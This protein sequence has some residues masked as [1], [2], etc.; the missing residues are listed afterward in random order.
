MIMSII[1][2]MT[3]IMAVPVPARAALPSAS[4]PPRKS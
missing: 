2:T 1:T 3:T 4:I